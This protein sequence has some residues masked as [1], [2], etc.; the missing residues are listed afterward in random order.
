MSNKTRYEAFCSANYVPIYSKPWWLDAVCGDDNWDVWLYEQGGRT[1]AA[2]PYY[3]ERRKYGLYITKAP[4]TQNNGILFSYPKDSSALSRAKLEEKVI[5][6]AMEFVDGLGLA[7]YE[8]QYRTEF[9]NWSPFS[10]CGCEALPRYTYVIEDTSSLRKVWSGLT[11][12]YRNHVKK[13]Q[14]NC[15]IEEMSDSDEFY[16][17]HAGIFSRQG[18]DVPFSRD[19]WTRLYSG[20]VR[21]NSGKTYVARVDS[22]VASVLFLVWDDRRVYQILGGT[23]PGFQGL[24]TYDALMWHGIEMAHEMGLAYDF[25]GS[26]IERIAKSFREFGGNPELYFRIRKLYSPEVVRDEAEAKAQKLESVLA[27]L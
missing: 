4:L 12:S 17:L 27:D 13:G 15:V 1:A 25:E 23:L 19:L 18:L 26:M 11:S 9:K 5:C 20:A 3:L 16:D 8:Q 14:R 7:V 10:W 2:M 21:N 24:E 6:A 22:E